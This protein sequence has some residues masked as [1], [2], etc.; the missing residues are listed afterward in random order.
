MIRDSGLPITLMESKQDCA[1][2]NAFGLA[3]PISSEAKNVTSSGLVYNLNHP[4]LELGTQTSSSNE[5]REDGIVKIS[6]ED[7]ALILM[8]CHD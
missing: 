7:G 1:K 4:I 8:E 3:N 2:S 5:T 6:Y